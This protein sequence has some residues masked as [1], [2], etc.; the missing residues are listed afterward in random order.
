MDRQ[1]VDRWMDRGMDGRMDGQTEEK[2]SAMCLKDEDIKERPN[3]SDMNSSSESGRP[4]PS[5]LADLRATQ[6]PDVFCLVFT[7]FT[8]FSVNC[9]YFKIRKFHIKILEFWLL[10][11]NRVDEWPGKQH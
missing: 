2:V 4:R 11:Q 10:L 6:T 7:V 3:L 5:V 8:W 1:M 9:H